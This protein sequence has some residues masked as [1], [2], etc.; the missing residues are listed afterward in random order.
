MKLL[1][2]E[3]CHFYS[4]LY[5]RLLQVCPFH[6]LFIPFQPFYHKYHSTETALLVD[7]MQIKSLL[8]LNATRK[9]LR[10]NGAVHDY[11]IRCRKKGLICSES[12]PQLTL[13]VHRQVFDALFIHPV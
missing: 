1:R 2:S 11:I 5:W 7:E 8:C 9:T 3:I 6:F 12:S 4:K 10:L 13:R